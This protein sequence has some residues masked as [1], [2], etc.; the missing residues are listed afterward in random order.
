M[1]VSP[2]ILALDLGTSSTRTA[3]FDSEAS[4][5]PNTTAQQTYPLLISADGA[6][7]LEPGVLLSAVRRCL[8]QT[9]Q[10]FRT[11]PALRG[12]SIAGIGV[13]CFWH[14][15]VGCDAKGAALTNIITW[16]D[17]RSRGDA[18]G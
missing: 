3:L 8:E 5:L 16:A 18:A 12:R 11:D 2:L 6:A 14:S 1:S 15:V 9:M 4:R 13:S 10:H 7:E 17:S